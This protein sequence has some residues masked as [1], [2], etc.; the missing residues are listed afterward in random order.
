MPA[1]AS[2]RPAKPSGPRSGSWERP[3]AAAASQQA[4]GS[5]A[6]SAR[7]LR[8]QPLISLSHDEGNGE[9]T[10]KVLRCQNIEIDVV[11]SR[12]MTA[13]ACVLV[14]NGVGIA[15]VEHGRP[16]F[17]SQRKVALRRFKPSI[18]ATFYAYCSKRPRRV[19]EEASSR[20]A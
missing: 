15:L 5:F 14:E 12:P 7:D 16:A 6:I 18:R 2:H 19:T 11:G 1:P 13:V 20:N 4:L 8:R 10:E 3:S 17:F 9:D